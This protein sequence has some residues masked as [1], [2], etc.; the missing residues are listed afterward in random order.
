MDKVLPRPWMAALLGTKNVRLGV[1]SRKSARFATSVAPAVA[2]TLKVGAVFMKLCG[3][4]RKSSMTW[5][6]PPSKARSYG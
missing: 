5:I 2:V 6:K 4:S 1:S 3:G